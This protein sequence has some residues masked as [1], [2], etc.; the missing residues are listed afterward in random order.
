MV[1]GFCRCGLCDENFESTRQ[2]DT[3]SQQPYHKE[4]LALFFKM[5]DKEGCVIYRK[6]DFPAKQIRKTISKGFKF[7]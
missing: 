2:Y 3:H 7:R 4:R 1:K 6:I 5:F